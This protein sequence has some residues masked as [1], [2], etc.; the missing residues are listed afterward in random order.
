VVGIYDVVADFELDVNYFDFHFYFFLG[1][2]EVLQ[3]LF[4]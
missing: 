4:H 1:D 2:L 3:V